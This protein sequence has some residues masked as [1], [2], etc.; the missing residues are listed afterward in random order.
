MKI[1][2]IQV[3]TQNYR[4]PVLF[5]S[6][7]LQTMYPTLFRKPPLVTTRRE[8]IDTLDGDFLDLDWSDPAG[9][10]RL[11]ILTHGLEG[12]SRG[13]Y[14]QGM[15]AALKRS[16][17]DVLAWNFRGCSGEPNRMLRSYHSGATEELQ[18]VLDHVFE[19]TGYEHIVL[20]GF[21][22]GGNLMLKFLG[23]A[24]D[25]IDQ[26]ITGSVAISVPCDLAS[27]AKKLEEW[28]NRFYMNR[29]MRSLREKVHEK[30]VRFPD[31]ISTDGLEAMR[32]FSEFD[33]A[34]TGPIH[35]FVDADD[36]WSQ[37]SCRQVLPDIS[38]PT[39]LISALD[40]PFLTPECFP[41]EAAKENP[42]LQL[43]TPRHGGHLG[44]VEFNPEKIYWSERKAV[45]F[46][47][48][49]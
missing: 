6:G 46:L 1:M 37:C 33:N 17:W 44:F 32:T 9:S 13:N 15:A 41:H 45:A 3:I 4:P 42:H 21:S 36:Y 34:Y 38:V 5:Q 11:A 43:N 48:E 24:G 19:E 47:D 35:G 22:L 18:V 8:R 26:R 23:D 28:Q 20:I 40:D 31:Q 10:K 27:S 7:H 39:L 16:G 29:F 12:S 49:L 14:C 25:S 30:A 2:N